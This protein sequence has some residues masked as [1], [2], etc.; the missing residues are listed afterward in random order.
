MSFIERSQDDEK[1]EEG[2]MHDQTLGTGKPTDRRTATNDISLAQNR[3]TAA[4][5][6]AALLP[7]NENA[8]SETKMI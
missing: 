1:E 4:P 5:I 3:H 8:G 2:C 7:K 6:P